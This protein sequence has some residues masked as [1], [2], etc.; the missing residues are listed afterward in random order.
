[1]KAIYTSRDEIDIRQNFSEFE[2]ISIA[3][4]GDDLE[5]FVA[6]VIEDRICDRSL[7]LRDP[8]LK[9]IIIN[10]IVSKANGMFQRAKCQLDHLCLLNNDRDRRKA[11]DT[12]PKDLFKTY[13]RILDRVSDS[14]PGNRSLVKRTLRWILFS[15][16]PMTAETIAMAVAI[17]I[18][19]DYVS[20]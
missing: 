10:G 17:E 5:L 7:R 8:M 18:N 11:L 4:R 12:L 13:R 14:T 6:A 15:E 2:S 16:D 1:M 3:A 9:G 19:S 20:W